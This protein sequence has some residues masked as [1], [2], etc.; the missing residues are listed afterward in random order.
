MFKKYN[1]SKKNIFDIFCKGVH[2]EFI[3]KITIFPLKSVK[4]KQN[5]QDKLHLKEN[6]FPINS[7]SAS[8]FPK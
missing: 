8:A 7:I 6:F 2:H 3:P 5:H 4:Y 1:I